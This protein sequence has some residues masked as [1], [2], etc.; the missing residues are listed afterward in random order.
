[1][2]RIDQIISQKGYNYSNIDLKLLH[3]ELNIEENEIKDLLTKM[4]AE[5]YYASVKERMVNGEY[6]GIYENT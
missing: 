6:S 2:S 3:Q 5:M 4:Q 1:M